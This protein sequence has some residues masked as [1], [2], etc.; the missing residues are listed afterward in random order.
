MYLFGFGMIVNF[1][2]LSL[3]ALYDYIHQIKINYLGS[4]EFPD[5]SNE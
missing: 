2:V 5:Q 3:H 1:V 4:L